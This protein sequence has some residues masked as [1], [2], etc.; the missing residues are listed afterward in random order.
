M[1]LPSR[2]ESAFNANGREHAVPA[3]T[4][5]GVVNIGLGAA[6]LMVD[7]T[8]FAVINVYRARRTLGKEAAMEARVA[9]DTDGA[10]FP[11]FQYAGRMA[12][13]EALT[14]YGAG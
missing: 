5:R 1:S 3:R 13:G 9:G 14:M 6:N 11:A 12:G 7:E 4:L 2:L 8:E 10:A